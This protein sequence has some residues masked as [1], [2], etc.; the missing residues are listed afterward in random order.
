MTNTAPKRRQKP[1]A[2]RHQ[3]P[4]DPNS[5]WFDTRGTVQYLEGFVTKSTLE[6]WRLFGNDGPPY[7]KLGPRRVVYERQA[8]DEWATNRRRQ[9][10]SEAVA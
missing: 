4:Y 10:T 7:I 6:K 5:K 1:Y 9:P 3:K 2:P 8:L